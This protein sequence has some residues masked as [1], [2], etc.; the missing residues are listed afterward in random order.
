MAPQSPEITINEALE[1]CAPGLKRMDRHVW[2]IR[3]TRRRRIPIE[4]RLEEG[5][6]VFEGA[7]RNGAPMKG[8]WELLRLNTR[9]P[10]L[11]RLVP[12]SNG[13]VGEGSVHISA[14]VPVE[15]G[16]NLFERFRPTIDD[17]ACAQVMLEGKKRGS[18][19]GTR[20][21]TTASDPSNVRLK[22]L[23]E[24]TGWPHRMGAEGRVLVDLGVPTGFHQAVVAPLGK[25]AAAWVDL[26]RTGE[27]PAPVRQALGM[28]LLTIGRVIRLVRAEV[29]DRAADDGEGEEIVR[30]EVRFGWAPTAGDLSH[31]LSA[32]ATACRL[33]ALEVRVLRDPRA[34]GAYLAD[35]VT[36]GSWP[37]LGGS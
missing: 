16:V 23:C 4:A 24:E 13:T 31:A 33:C 37:G 35:P 30:L 1:R 17:L 15:D 27:T 14:E 12:S 25:G 26:E 6:I 29:E 5:W 18:C 2:R 7:A 8:P 21:I 10:G 11:A 32:L 22:H 36:G 3:P 28:L 20:P 19:S 9:M 34:A